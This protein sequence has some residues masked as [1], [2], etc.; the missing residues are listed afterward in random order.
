MAMET[1][2]TKVGILRGQGLVLMIACQFCDDAASD[3]VRRRLKD[4]AS[5]GRK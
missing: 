4:L 1:R 2:F 3:E 5:G